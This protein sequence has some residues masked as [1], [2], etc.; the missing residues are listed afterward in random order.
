[1]MRSGGGRAATTGAKAGLSV[2]P[3]AALKGRS[4][5]ALHAAVCRARTAE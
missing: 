5:T 1:M 2:C 4:S 3:Y